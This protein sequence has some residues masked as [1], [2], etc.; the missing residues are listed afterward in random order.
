MRSLIPHPV[1][2]SFRESNEP[3]CFAMLFAHFAVWVGHGCGK[4]I[5]KRMTGRSVLHGSGSLIRMKPAATRY[6]LD[7]HLDDG[8]LH[9][10]DHPMINWT[11]IRSIIEK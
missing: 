4:M 5:G 2:T 11:I 8:R 1:Y 10:D 6:H 7:D 3:L 9:L